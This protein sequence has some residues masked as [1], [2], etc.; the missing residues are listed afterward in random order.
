MTLM[1]VL[2]SQKTL[3][4]TKVVT[5]NFIN[6]IIWTFT[7]TKNLRS[8]L[9]NVALNLFF[10]KVMSFLILDFLLGIFL[11]ADKIAFSSISITYIDNFIYFHFDSLIKFLTH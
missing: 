10:S 6:V 1:K 7:T 3:A 9:Y 2:V 11:M 4:S 8:N 5:K